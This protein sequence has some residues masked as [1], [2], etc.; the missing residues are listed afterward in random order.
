MPKFKSPH[1]ISENLISLYEKVER[2]IT[3]DFEALA[4]NFR[5]RKSI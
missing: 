4:K 1:Y 5:K 3:I 2:P